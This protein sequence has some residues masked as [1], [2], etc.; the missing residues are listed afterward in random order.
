[1]AA[2]SMVMA[3]WRPGG[4]QWHGEMAASKSEMMKG[5]NGDNVGNNQ[6]ANRTKLMAKIMTMKW[7]RRNEIMAKN[8]QRKPASKMAM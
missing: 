1:M 5:G 8:H 7:R 3:K 6:A 4:K 2:A